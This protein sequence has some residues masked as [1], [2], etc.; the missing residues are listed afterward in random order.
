MGEVFE[1][2]SVMASSKPSMNFATATRSTTR[3]LSA[4]SA[5][6]SDVIQDGSSA[7]GG[8]TEV[9]F[10]EPLFTSTQ[11]VKKKRGRPKKNQVPSESLGLSQD[12]TS[13][14]SEVWSCKLCS[15][16]F[17]DEDDRLMQCER[18]DGATCIKCLG[19]EPVVYDMLKGRVDLHWY[20]G[21]CDKLAM[22]AV[23]ADWEIE[24]KCAM[25]MAKINSKIDEMQTNI[26]K[27]ADKAIVDDLC[28]EVA[29]TKKLLEGANSDI[30]KLA[31]RVDLMQNEPDEIEKRKKNIVI[32]GLPE[33][34]TTTVENEQISDDNVSTTDLVMSDMDACIE[35][36][37][38]IGVDDVTPKA[39]RRLGKK[40]QDGKPRPIKV[41]LS[42]EDEKT[43]V[44]KRGPKVRRVDPDG[45]SFDPTR[46]F[47][48]PDMT[49]L[50]REEDIRLRGELKKKRAD[51]PN[52]IIKGKKLVRRTPLPEPP[53]GA[54][55]EEQ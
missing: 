55:G 50:Q 45:V 15:I 3:S 10:S 54:S 20:C 48:C 47:V 1:L 35:L 32:R 8:S 14:Q 53:D 12:I 5:R 26:D 7:A 37:N 27:K 21:P 17:S 13:N 30:A 31:N 22:S 40:N 52:W 19:M 44:I 2:N 41:I 25:Y 6:G 33:H 29:T 51:D 39:V 38:S 18:C 36:L 28:V 42:S 23:R 46:I 16:E 34:G 43:R 9:S 24:E 11:T 4:S 49:I